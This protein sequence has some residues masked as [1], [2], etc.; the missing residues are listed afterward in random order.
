M[1][2]KLERLRCE[3]DKARNSKN[4]PAYFKLREKIE[5]EIAKTYKQKFVALEDGAHDAPDYEV[6]PL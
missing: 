5:A 3:A 4:L 1:S 2:S 6:I